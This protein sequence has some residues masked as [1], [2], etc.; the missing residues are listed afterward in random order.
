KVPAGLSYFVINAILLAFALIYLGRDFV[1][2][3]AVGA[4]IVTVFVEIFAQLPTLTD[5]I[6]LNV[7]IGSILYGISIGMTLIAA[8]APSCAHHPQVRPAPSS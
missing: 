4:G 6:I 2:K 5:D 1:I 7:S 3:S 8:P